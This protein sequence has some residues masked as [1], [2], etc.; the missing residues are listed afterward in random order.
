MWCRSVCRADVCVGCS[1]YKEDLLF[2][3]YGSLMITNVDTI[4]SVQQ[5]SPTYPVISGT[6]H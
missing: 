4:G 1:K 6:E 3:E 2:D 5:R